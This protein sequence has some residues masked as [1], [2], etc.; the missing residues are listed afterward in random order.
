MTRPPFVSRR[1]VLRAGA[2]GM[3]QVG[4]VRAEEI[5]A[6]D[7]AAAAAAPAAEDDAPVSLVFAGD[8]VLDGRPGRAI[9]RLPTRK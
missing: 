5:R 7:P 1:L 6:A 4:A 8:V 3:V 9:A 2:A